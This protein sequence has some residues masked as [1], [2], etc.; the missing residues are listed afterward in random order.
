MTAQACV[1]TTVLSTQLSEQNIALRPWQDSHRYALLLEALLCMAKS[2]KPNTLPVRAVKKIRRMIDFQRCTLALLNDD[3]ETYRVQTLLET[4]PDVPQAVAAAVSLGRGVLGQFLQSEETCTLI[5]FSAYGPRSLDQVD[6][7][8]ENGLLQSVLTL[9][10]RA[11]GKLLGAIAFGTHQSKAYEALD[12][13]LALVFATH[14][15]LALDHGELVQ[16]LKS[17]AKSMQDDNREREQAQ[18]ALSRVELSTTQLLTAISSILIGVDAQGLINQWNPAAERTFAVPADTIIG[19][20]IATCPL[21]WDV[22]PVISGIAEAGR[23]R[24]P[25]RIDDV[26]FTRADG[27]EGFL[28]LTANP[29]IESSGKRAG[30]LVLAADITNRKILESQ[31]AQAQKLESIGQLAAGIAHE[32]N[33]PT[34]YVSDNTHFLQGAFGDL[35]RLLEHYARLLQAT[36]AGEVPNELLQRIEALASAIDINYLCEEIPTAI[37]QSLDGLRQVS[38]IVRAMKEFSHP[39]EK[40]KSIVDLNRILENAITIARNEWKLVAEMVTDF[41]LS[42]PLI[43]CQV[44]DI[45]QVFLNVLVNAAHAIAERMKN[46]NT[47]KGAITVST[48]K[49]GQSVEIRIADTGTGIPVA[50]REKVFEPFFTSKEVGKGTGQ[51]LAI[52][53]NTV[54]NK[55]KG[56][57]TFDTVPGQG[58]TFLI[59]LPLKDP[60]SPE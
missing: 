11:R 5:D 1:T 9:A 12:V 19:E 17:Q 25:R 60:Q 42:L 59:S 41:D 29:I 52:A 20:P 30:F 18:T 15:A 22:T 53:R 45:N 23:T 47:D 36:R 48:R 38:E 49:S 34:Q 35:T 27:S 33:T 7:G 50:A 10:L 54:V 2:S 24:Q 16:K 56:T 55:H 14:L 3:G 58:T 6:D 31:L 4:R 40:D 13:E 28:G 21:A 32:I 46:E 8:L 39:G 44:S 57:I 51:G 37:Q 43:P 26:R